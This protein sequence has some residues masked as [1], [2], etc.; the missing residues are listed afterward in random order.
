MV[1]CETLSLFFQICV[2]LEVEPVL[3]ILLLPS[4]GWRTNIL[5]QILLL[6]LYSSKNL[7]QFLLCKPL[8][9]LV[10]FTDAASHSVFL[11]CVNRPFTESNFQVWMRWLFFS[12]PWVPVEQVLLLSQH[13]STREKPVAKASESQNHRISW[14]RRDPKWSLSPNPSPTQHHPNLTPMAKS[15]VP[16]LP[17]L[18]QLRA[19]SIAL[20]AVP[21]PLPSGA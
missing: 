3:M 15:G 13:S 12:Q 19:V 8:P 2:Y 21:C 9:P 11:L 6:T 7:W 17:E 14:F 5:C 16:T 1:I 18:Q 4:V 20:G 10:D